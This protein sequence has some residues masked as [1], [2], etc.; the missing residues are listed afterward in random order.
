VDPVPI[1]LNDASF[2]AEA[3]DG[4]V[5][6][7]AIANFLKT[8]SRLKAV[9]RP[10]V[11]ATQISLLDVPLNR[12]MATLASFP[13]VVDKEWWRFIRNVD[14]HSPLSESD[15]CDVP[16]PR[17]HL[18]GQDD[19]IVAALWAKK[20]GSF[21][22]SFAFDEQWK[23]R[24]LEFSICNCDGG[25]HRPLTYS[26][27]NISCPDQVDFWREALLDFRLT[28]ASSATIYECDAYQLKMYLRDH[29][30][31][32]VHVYQSAA[33]NRCVGRIR[34]DHVEVMEDD[35]FSGSVKKASL[36]LMA[37]K[38]AELLRAWER[39]RNGQLPN[40]I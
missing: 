27:P 39:C 29:E 17:E 6:R 30:P 7:E 34:F 5:I 1:F 18:L 21:L 37:D 8:L 9:G 4:W 22:I 19:S 13:E 2:P 38:Q 15:I 16:E 10:T 3:D 23:R 36:A 20:N 31:P 25:L 26:C 14:Q 24:D 28:E 32:H 40:A 12:D 35:G 11:L 33:P